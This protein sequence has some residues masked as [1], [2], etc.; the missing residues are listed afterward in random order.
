M[1]L[2]TVDVV[3]VSLAVLW[4]RG[5]REMMVEDGLGMGIVSAVMMVIFIFVFHIC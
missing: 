3:D 5:R 4:R 1:L 2:H